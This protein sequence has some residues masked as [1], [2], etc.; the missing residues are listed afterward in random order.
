MPKFDHASVWAQ[1]LQDEPQLEFA[2][3]VG[4]RAKGNARADSDWDI[5]LQWFP[6][7]DLLAV[8]AATETLRRKLALA[9]HVSVDAIDL[10]ELRRAN[11]AM[12]ASVAEEGIPLAGA[13]SLAW[14]HF[15]RRTWRDLEDFY[16]D[17]QHAA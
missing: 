13:D 2:V 5:A 10:I 1:I 9:L 11:L 14:A 4:S 15:L 6:N 12:R 3:L 7:L 17:R 8:L 16:W